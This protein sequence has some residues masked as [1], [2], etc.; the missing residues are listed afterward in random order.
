MERGL[1]LG[2]GGIRIG[3]EIMV[4]GNILLKNYDDV[5]NWSCCLKTVSTAG[6]GA[7][8]SR[9]QHGCCKSKSKNLADHQCSSTTG[10]IQVCVAACKLWEVMR[11]TLRFD[12]PRVL[13]L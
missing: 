11:R 6:G 3:A 4:E 12:E 8:N 7:E 2:I 13:S 5:L 1:A 10:Q 9:V